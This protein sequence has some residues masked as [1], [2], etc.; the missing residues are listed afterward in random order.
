M[1]I[2]TL[3]A[4]VGRGLATSLVDA[5][6]VGCRVRGD[7]AKLGADVPLL[8]QGLHEG[9]QQCS[10]PSSSEVYQEVTQI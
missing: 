7:D 5:K 4:D 6:H 8:Q 1:I 9:C 2:G 10:V 3:A